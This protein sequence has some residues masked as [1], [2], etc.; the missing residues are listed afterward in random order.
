[1]TMTKLE[2]A[3][4]FA[5]NGPLQ[6]ADGA[7]EAYA[8]AARALR[9]SIRATRAAKKNAIAKRKDARGQSKGDENH[10]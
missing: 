5:A 9:R 8:L 1:M 7:R 2:A 6:D 10:E 4:W 3:E